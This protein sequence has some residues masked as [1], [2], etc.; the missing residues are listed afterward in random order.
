M[1][2]DTRER[3]SLLYILFTISTLPSLG[4][5]YE[6]FRTKLLGLKRANDVLRDSVWGS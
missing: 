2:G 6:S 4:N 3:N 5:G 1:V